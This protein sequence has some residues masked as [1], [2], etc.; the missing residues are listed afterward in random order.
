APESP[1]PAAYPIQRGLTRGFRDEARNTGDTERMQMWAGQ[2]AILAQ[3]KPAG[4]IT[5]LLWEQAVSLLG[6][7]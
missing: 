1:A 2:S 6:W 4:E 5:Q 7:G 3:A